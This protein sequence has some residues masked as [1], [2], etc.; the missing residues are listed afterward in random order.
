MVN[1][2]Q[3]YNKITYPILIRVTVYLLTELYTVIN[4]GK[5]LNL[6]VEICNYYVDLL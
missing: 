6:F 1:I 4:G 3:S 2:K 5:H